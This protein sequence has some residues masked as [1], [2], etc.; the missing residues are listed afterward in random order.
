M[1][2]LSKELLFS[3]S[4]YR[5]HMVLQ[6][7]VPSSGHYFLPASSHPFPWPISASL[8]SPRVLSFSSS[9]GHCFLHHV[10]FPMGCNSTAVS[11]RD[12]SFLLVYPTAHRDNH[13]NSSQPCFLLCHSLCS[14]RVTC[15][16]QKKFKFLC[17]VFS[18][19]YHLSLML[20][21]SRNVGVFSRLPSN[22]P[23][24]AGCPQIKLS[25]DTFYLEMKS[26]PTG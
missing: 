4:N 24:P 21:I 12:F 19:S 22:S 8:N 20:P 16:P 1:V 18:I 11:R 13:T 10:K 23:T 25:S 9:K 3:L 14:R 2:I 6:A 26:D 7:S 15:C 17:L 5:S